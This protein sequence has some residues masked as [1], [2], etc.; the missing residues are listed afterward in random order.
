MTSQ[1]W[2]IA[3]TQLQVALKV[4]LGTIL[5]AK[6]LLRKD[7]STSSSTVRTDEDEDEGE[8]FAPIDETS[9]LIRTEDA[10]T[11]TISGLNHDPDA[12]IKE[13][14]KQAEKGADD[15]DSF[16][17][18]SQVMTLMTTDVCSEK[19]WDMTHF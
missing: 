10:A 17:S 13:D 6:T 7:V 9:N 16:S 15:G 1:L 11:G 14:S 19:H 2:S 18:K 5:F 4:E 12:R 3:T 8:L